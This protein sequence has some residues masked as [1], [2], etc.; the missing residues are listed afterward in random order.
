VKISQTY[1]NAKKS[2]ELAQD[3]QAL[4]RF[5]REARVVSALNHPNIC[6]IYEIGMTRAEGS[7]TILIFRPN[8]PANGHIHS[9]GW[10]DES[11]S[12]QG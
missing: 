12:R 2:S 9:T 5:R 10:T 1:P 11:R 3:P 6:T 7:L 4:E 8:I